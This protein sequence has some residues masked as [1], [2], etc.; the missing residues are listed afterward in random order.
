VTA[1]YKESDAASSVDSVNPDAFFDDHYSGTLTAMIA[2]VIAE[3]GPILDAILARRI[4][5]A[6]GWVRTGSKIRERVIGIARRCHKYTTEDVGDFY[7]PSRVTG[8]SSSSFRRPANDE[9]IRATDEISLIELAYLARELVSKGMAG[10]SLLHAMSRELGLQKLTAASRARL[11]KAANL[12]LPS[13]TGDT[14]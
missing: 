8:D 12:S 9:S 13:D 4:T 1:F 11:E 14:A 6:H 7:W 3:E 2:H 5:R 10:D